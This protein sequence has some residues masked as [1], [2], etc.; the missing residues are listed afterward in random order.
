M[1]KSA[2]LFISQQPAVVNGQAAVDSPWLTVL[3]VSRLLQIHPVSVYKLCY[4]RRIPFLKHP[5]IGIRI[6]RE[7]LN[8]HLAQAKTPAKPKRG[9]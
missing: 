5:G 3:E 9:R 6:P 7:E 8:R 4:K 1:K 2:R